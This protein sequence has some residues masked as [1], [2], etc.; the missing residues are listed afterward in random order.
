M[1]D[2]CVEKEGGYPGALKMGGW[3]DMVDY[4]MGC[5]K[6]PVLCILKDWSN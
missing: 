6:L 1:G 3:L 4:K 5:K 2:G